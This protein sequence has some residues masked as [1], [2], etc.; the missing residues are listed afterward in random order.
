[1][2]TFT[3]FVFLLLLEVGS[4]A[5]GDAAA[6]IQ[7]NPESSA[8][9][10]QSSSLRKGGEKTRDKT[11]QENDELDAEVTKFLL[12]RYLDGYSSMPP[13]N[14]ELDDDE[15]KKPPSVSKQPSW[16]HE[17]SDISLDSDVILGE[18]EN[19]MR[20]QLLCNKVPPGQIGSEAPRRR[21][22]KHGKG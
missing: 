18:L 11:K 14:G 19:G 20:Y 22:S 4:C 10:Q 2:R 17:K 3:V 13:K 7:G 5:V 9:E 6:G 21:R 15:I 12:R 8:A 1:M 16:P